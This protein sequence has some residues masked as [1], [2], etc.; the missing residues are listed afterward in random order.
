VREQLNLKASIWRSNNDWIG[1]ALR[2]GRADKRQSAAEEQA[3]V[4]KA[5]ERGGR[6]GKLAL[7]I[8]ISSVPAQY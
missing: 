3:K 2:F 1:L 5:R 6:K 4:G 8:V 7:H